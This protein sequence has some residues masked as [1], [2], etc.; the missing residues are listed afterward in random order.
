MTRDLARHFVRFYPRAW[1]ARYEEEFVALLEARSDI[2]WRI[3]LDVSLGAAREWGRWF[4]AWPTREPAGD[5]KS[6]GWQARAEWCVLLAIT[7][8]LDLTT[9]ATASG[10]TRVVSVDVPGFAG[11]VWLL[12][13]VLVRC[14]WVRVWPSGTDTERIGAR[15]LGGWCVVLFVVATIARLDPGLST[16]ANDPWLVRFSMAPT[17]LVW[18]AMFALMQSTPAAR[19]RTERRDELL[20]LRRRTGVP[21]SPLGLH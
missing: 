7:L 6:L 11:L 8:V 1:R 15:E 18:T 12:S 13:V 3:A 4:V 21:S 14:Y 5:L 20:T 2:D 16:P 10:L 17:Q 9:R 19:A